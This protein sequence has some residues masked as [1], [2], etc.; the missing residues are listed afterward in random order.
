MDTNL[1][2]VIFYILI[3][4]DS[5]DDHFFLKKAIKKV[6]PEAI[7]ESLYD[8]QEA[9][10][11]LENCTD[12][13]NLI[14]LDLNMNRVSG[15]TTMKRIRKNQT[16]QKVP[17]IILTTSNNNSEKQALLEL[18]ANEFYTKPFDSKDLIPIVEEVRH[19]WLEAVLLSN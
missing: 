17:V 3:V 16:L 10:E 7:V 6:I 12:L 15:Q 5:A 19:K 14:F 13:P 9:L 1:N 18:G 8:G 11:Y 2:N 4:D